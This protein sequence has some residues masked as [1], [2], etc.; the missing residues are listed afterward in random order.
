MQF[1]KRFIDKKTGKHGIQLTYKQFLIKVHD[2]SDGFW[3]ISPTVISLAT[4]ARFEK[5]LK[6]MAYAYNIRNFPIKKTDEKEDK[7]IIGFESVGFDPNAGMFVINFE[8][9]INLSKTKVA[10]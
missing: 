7:W 2:I 1:K 3:S 5:E 4:V 10:P 8:F 6:D 9:A